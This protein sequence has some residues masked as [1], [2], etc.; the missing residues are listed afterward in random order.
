LNLQ[1]CFNAGLLK[2]DKPSKE[3]TTKS[4]QTAETYLIKAEHTIK[5]QDFDLTILC[6]YTSM[7]HAARAL[8]YTDGIKEKSHVCLILYI[9]Q[10]YPQ[11]SNEM[12]LMDSYR[13]TRHTTLYGLEF[14]TT[15]EQAQESIKDAQN[16]LKKIK[17]ILKNKTIN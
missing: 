9:K 16:I 2:K 15:K 12:N 4:F 6:S 13:R 11:L 14:M 17:N 8:L 7:F 3:K 1:E 10:K 5:N